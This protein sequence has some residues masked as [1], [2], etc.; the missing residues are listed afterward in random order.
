VPVL[1]TETAADAALAASPAAAPPVTSGRSRQE[2]A[3]FWRWLWVLLA[4]GAVAFVA[5]DLSGKGAKPVA[6]VAREPAASTAAPEPPAS[7]L[8]LAPPASL[9]V[10]SAGAVPAPAA[11]RAVP[12]PE[13]TSV[14]TAS[15]APA[16]SCIFA[17]QTGLAVYQSPVANRPSSYVYFESRGDIQVCIRDAQ[18]KETA[19]QLSQGG[20]RNVPGTPPYTVRVSSWNQARIFFE[21]LQVRLEEGNADNGVLLRPHSPQ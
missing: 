4:V 14:K 3:G 20:T 9:P 18:G 2:S 5:I 13:P 7:T 21:G 12:Q 8:P 15:A 6:T 10:T 19:F 11:T 1:K 17:P 16:V